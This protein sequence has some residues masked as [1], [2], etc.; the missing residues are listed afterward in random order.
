MS[1]AQPSFSI[2]LWPVTVGSG[3]G[4]ELNPV[5]QIQ[6]PTSSVT[7]NY[8]DAETPALFPGPSFL[9]WSPAIHSGI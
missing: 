6:P 7:F 2:A 8:A 9:S 5:Q 1:S 4:L 3:T